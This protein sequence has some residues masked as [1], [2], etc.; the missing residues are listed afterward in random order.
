MNAATG[1]S[2]LKMRVLK[3]IE[4]IFYRVILEGSDSW[5]SGGTAFSFLIIVETVILIFCLVCGSSVNPSQTPTYDDG[6]HIL[7][8]K[9]D[10]TLDT[11]HVF[12]FPDA[13]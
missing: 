3:T 8:V 9:S 2:K 7:T 6:S 11:S 10:L 1:Q 12:I 5:L 4:A 13:D